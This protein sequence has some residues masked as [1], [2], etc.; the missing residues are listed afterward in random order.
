MSRSRF[1]SPWTGLVILLSASMLV[2]PRPLRAET[3]DV[4]MTYDAVSDTKVYPKPELPKMG[5]A[6]SRIID[7][8]FG[9]PVIRV[10][11]EKTSGG[12]PVVTP[13]GAAQNTWN[14]DSTLFVVQSA[15]TRVIP[16][17]F[18]PKT[19][20]VSRV[21]GL[22]V[23]PDVAGDTPFSF[24]EKDVCYGKDIRRG[25]IV[26]FDFATK[27]ATDVLDVATVTGIPVAGRHLGTFGVSANDCFNLTFGGPGQNRDMIL[28]WYDA[29][30]KTR[31]V[32]NTQEGTLDGRPIPDAPH[33]LQHAS[34]I[35]RSGRYIWT[36]PS[37]GASVPWVWDV[38]EGTVYPM[39][40]QALG[41]RAVGYGDMVNDVHLWLY[42]TMDPEG[43]RTPKPL[44]V[45]PPGEPYFAYDSHQSW[46]NARP[47]RR[48]PILIS[49]YHRIG[50]GDPK[51]V[52][53]DEVIALATD[54]SKRIWRFAHHRS[55]VHMPTRTDDGQ[56][57][58]PRDRADLARVQPYNFWDTPRGNVSQDGRFFM[59]TS[60]WEDTLGKDRA[61]RF[62]DDVFIVRLE[63]EHP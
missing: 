37:R 42:R 18:D 11:D 39:T 38:R 23:L 28:L 35:D 41:H 17:R 34:E 10:S 19:L 32:W 31:H 33:F 13:A 61:G 36:A 54:G 16:F 5:P 9:C 12:D 62:R 45:H 4:P 2:V 44:M 21:P 14:T 29:V 58:M 15:G 43:I 25:V 60:N 47:G 24:R 30:H 59:F 57:V 40:V 52:W 7:P 3:S 63:R 56:R 6:G 20:V 48:V 1:P 46:N 49:T 50:A 27:T 53:G 8:S 55:A 22:E 26:R 51:C